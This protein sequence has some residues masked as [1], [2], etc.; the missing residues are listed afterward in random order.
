MSRH[1]FAVVGGGMVGCA[2]ASLL[3]RCG[4][5]VALIEA[6]GAPKFDPSVGVGLRVSA[7]S[8][9]SAAILDAAGAWPL[10]EAERHCPY[11]RM[12]VEEAGGGAV[13]FLAPQLGLERLG[14]IIENDLVH[15]ALWAAASGHALVDMFTGLLPTGI[16]AREDG[17]DVTLEDGQLLSA[18]LLLGADGA[19]SMVRRWLGAERETW[20]YNQVGVVAV[21]GKSRANP[22]V[23]WQRFLA[24][25]PLA[26]LPLEDGRS[27]IVWS[28]PSREAQRLMQCDDDAF[29]AALDE[30]SVDWLGEVTDSGPR[31]AFPLSMGLSDRYVG[32]RCVLLGDAA[33]VV[34]PLAGQGVNLGFADVAALLEHLLAARR[35]GRPP[36]DDGTLREFERRRRSQ[37]N[38]MA[39]G[40][41]GIGGLFLR[42]ELAVLRRMG[43]GLVRRSRLARETFA[44]RAAGRDPGAPRLS[45]GVPLS[46]LLRE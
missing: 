2:A 14:T 38:L 40:I 6:A 17:I 42:P 39:M 22:G 34:H 30:A 20:D 37:A 35:A 8:P 25:G 9:G 15:H 28:Q 27:S 13:E 12:R 19:D 33:H 3:A 1:D 21:V 29:L 7:I 43:M 26:F 23:A 5:S 24:G 10:I 32:R 16:S 31:A 45:R 41:H 36:G 44:R 11:R 4:Y 46:T 18:D